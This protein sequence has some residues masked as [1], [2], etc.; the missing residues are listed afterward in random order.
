MLVLK[1]V[2]NLRR[3]LSAVLL[4][5]IVNTAAAQSPAAASELIDRPVN[6]P[7]LSV[8]EP[9]YFVIG[10]R[11][12]TTARFQLSFKY[13]LFDEEEG[14]AARFDFL[15]DIHFGYTQLALWNVEENS[16][17]FDG[18]SYRPS[19]FKDIYTH[20]DRWWPNF[21]RTGYEHESN[22]QAGLESRGVDAIYIWPAWVKQT[23]ERQFVIAPK[24]ISYYSESR[25]N[26]DIA[27]YRSNM[28]LWLRYGK[29]DGW[30][31]SVLMRQG[32]NQH[33]MIQVDLSYPI[34]K[35]FYARTGGYVYIQYFHGY[36][37]TLNT[38]N[39][40]TPEQF[41]IGYAIVR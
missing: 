6:E 13:R 23:G 25:N 26:P 4:L 15:K 19:F 28:D 33:A 1:T 10:G 2:I 31:T 22:G 38:Y 20:K 12:E 35:N 34:R 37:Q 30:L 14:L 8:N 16:A 7:A 40:H 41:R 29:E 18:S 11:E 24:F 9:M 21:I 17:P 3:E 36:G 32:K 5:C 27:E 39:Q